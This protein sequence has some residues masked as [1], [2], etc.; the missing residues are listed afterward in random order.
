MMLL[1]VKDLLADKG[2][3]ITSSLSTTAVSTAKTFFSW[4]E[5]NGAECQS[6]ST[7][8][9]S[10]LQSVFS[11]IKSTVRPRVQRE[12]MWGY[13]HIVRSSLL[14]RQKWIIVIDNIPGGTPSPI[15]F[16]YVTDKIFRQLVKIRSPVETLRSTHHNRDE[17]TFEEESGLR[18]AA[19][20]VCRT[21][22]KKFITNTTM[23][24][25]I[26]ELV[27]HDSEDRSDSTS[28]WTQLASRG[29]L[30]QVKDSTYRVFHA[31]EL[32]VRQ[33]GK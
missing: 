29:G 18:Y 19:G 32:V 13:Y 25:C 23:I 31:M 30:V 11:R 28:E 24:E 33:H 21:L 10:D 20:Y 26:D 3:E 6:F 1:A 8:I 15:F 2:F 17:L 5:E 14:F 22:K 27:D 7:E 16:Q 9:L 12:K 4:C